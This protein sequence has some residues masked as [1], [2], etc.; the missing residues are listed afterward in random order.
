MKRRSAMLLPATLMA[1]RLPVVSSTVAPLLDVFRPNEATQAYT[2][3]NSPA[4]GC[5]VQ[6]FVNGLLMLAV[7]DYGIVA[8]T[9]T[10]TEQLITAGSIIQVHYWVSV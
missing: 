1:Q 7:E 6:V 5:P 2:L 10:F 8:R 9:L 4:S 3:T